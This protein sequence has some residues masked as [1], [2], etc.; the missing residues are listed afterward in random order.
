MAVSG[1]VRADVDAEFHGGYLIKKVGK[2]WR[3]YE[4]A[5]SYSSTSGG[6]TALGKVMRDADG[7]VVSFETLA[8]AQS[9]I[10][11]GCIIY[12]EILF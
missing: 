4:D 6:Y 10:D 9:W 3:V 1:R 8:Q 11:K 2:H 7:K 5:S 12:P